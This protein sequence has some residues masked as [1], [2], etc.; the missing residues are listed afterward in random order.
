[1][2]VWL[3]GC[4]VCVTVV[5]AGLAHA[6]PAADAAT[7]Y[8]HAAQ[9]EESGDFEAA[10]VSIEEGLAAAPRDLSL[11]GLKGTVQL[12]LRDY[13]G[14]LATYQ[15]YLEAGAR[16][17]NR[18]E[19][20]K[21]VESLRAVQSTFLDIA[22]TGSPATIYLD[23][24]TQGV[25]CTAAPSCHRAILPGDYKVIAERPGFE[26]WT[27]R[28]TV[29]SDQT[30]TMSIALAETPSPVAIRVSPADARIAIDGAPY[31]PS[32]ALA[33]GKHRV[34]IARDGYAEARVDAVCHEGKPVALDVAL[35]PLVAIRVAPASATLVLDGTPLAVRDGR[36][37][38]APGAHELIAR[39]PGFLDQRIAI[40][41]ERPADYQIAIALVPDAA[42]H[43]R[44]PTL[45]DVGIGLVE[46]GAVVLGIGFVTAVNSQPQGDG[47]RSVATVLLVAGGAAVVGGVIVSIVVPQR[48]PRVARI[49]P[50]LGTGS[51]GLAVAGGF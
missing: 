40:P 38:I 45:H 43:S 18:R 17:A 1:M 10:L 44:N 12:K 21:I 30:T 11:L 31:D 5:G 15:L 23:S 35:A 19:A 47:E 41:T 24:K 32:A 8:R 25:F 37:A 13:A 49:V 42:P 4:V 28:I 33:A 16:G 46:G 9:L 27:G 7:R 6:A 34:V 39:A 14:A 22:V 29:A 26:R 50:S 2:R 3:G 20:E 36:A 51:V 48:R